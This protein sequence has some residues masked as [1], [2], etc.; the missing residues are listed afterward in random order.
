MI[1]VDASV[2]VSALVPGDTHYEAGS[3]WLRHVERD[4]EE[5]AIPAL[6]L[7]EIAGAI[8]RRTGDAELGRKAVSLV[9][10]WPGLRVV[11]LDAGTG[12]I[13]AEVA[14]QYRLRGADAVYLAAARALRAPVA[15]LD[16]ELR[17]R[18]NS[19]VPVID[20]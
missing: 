15:T 13:A 1:V 10:R 3:R 8:A 20:V 9:L 16:Q 12:E 17:D 2:W 4:E 7:P 14:A 11:P 5:I 18:A 6:A 19:I